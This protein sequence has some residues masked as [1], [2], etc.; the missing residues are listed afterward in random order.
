MYKYLRQ[1]IFQEVTPIKLCTVKE[2]SAEK[3]A[4]KTETARSNKEG[5]QLLLLSR[6]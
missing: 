6:K 5:E 4:D 3:R 1:N 2:E